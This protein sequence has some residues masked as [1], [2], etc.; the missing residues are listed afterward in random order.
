MVTDFGLA[1]VVDEATMTR[2]GSISGTPQYM[3]PEQARGESV[4][5]R[6]DLFSLGS[7][8]YTA[9]TGH[10]PFRAET[11]FGVIKRVCDNDPRSL[12]ESN[13]DIAEWMAAF[14]DKL[15]SKNRGDRFES[16]E[17]VAN[18]LH[19]E[20]GHM[21][22]PTLIPQPARDWCQKPVVVPAISLEAKPKES[23]EKPCATGNRSGWKFLAIGASLLALASVSALT[24]S[25]FYGDS[26]DH[27]EPRDMV[28][29]TIISTGDG[30]GNY[31]S[32]LALTQEENE[33]LEKFE[34]RISTT[35]DVQDGGV[36]F[37]RSNLGKLNV[38]THDKATVEM[39][40]NHTVAA[41]DKEIAAKI[42]KALK[43]N[44][45][46]DAKEIEGKLR[47]GKDAAIIAKFP[48]QKLTQKEIDAAEDLDELK[49]ALLIRNNSHHSNAEFNLFVPETFSLDLVTSAGP[50]KSTEIDGSVKLTTHGGN[51]EISNVSGT[52][53]IMSHGGNIQAG[54]IGS[55]T[56][57]ETHGGHIVILDVDGEFLATTHGGRISARHVNGAAEA[58]TH[59]GKI[60]FI[61]AS[62][63]VKAESRGGRITILKAHDAVVAEAHAGK[64]EVNFVDQPKGDSKL[65][66]HSG[67]VQVGYIEGIGFD[68][69]ASSSNGKISGAFLDGIRIE[70]SMQHEL[71]DGTAKLQ[72]TSENGSVKFTVIKED[73][74][75][76]H[77]DT[78]NEFETA[79]L[80]FQ[81]AYET[82]MAGKIDEAIELHKAAAQYE[83]TKVLATYNL[84]CAWALKG[85]KDRAFKALNQAV[86]FGMDDV[87]QFD[88]DSDLDS[89]RDDPRYEEVISRVKAM[90][91]KNQSSA[92]TAKEL[93]RL[94]SRGHSMFHS[95]KFDK[96]EKV[97]RTI[98]ELEPK[99]L[100]AAY[101][102]SSSIHA[103][104]KLD[105]ALEL[106]KI[107]ANSDSSEFASKA[108]Y[109]IACICSLK[110]D[111]DGAIEH[112]KK[113]INAGF[114]D[115]QHMKHDEELANIHDDKRFEELIALAKE[116]AKEKSDCTCEEEDENITSAGDT[117]F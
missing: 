79:Q 96:S 52:A 31:G 11:V 81:K 26:G 9:S 86:D 90:W 69:E 47:D 5:P 50:I 73:E 14:I 106:H 38:S 57:I 40:L 35:I 107:V 37:L 114:V 83:S 65:S 71:N 3:S 109:N 45:E 117:E 48:I 36:L 84:G 7:V 2:S 6:S 49:D 22:N 59:G 60:E 111:T 17:Q 103:L 77:Q 25:G 87:S 72:I 78:V 23:L 95:E 85:E 89:L 98:L 88:G 92:E 113:A 15:H 82:H 102:L 61:E 54:N 64:V 112:L 1:R 94:V 13:P 51:I 56:N 99:N 75:D 20:I 24:L 62:G 21:Q 18:L 115:I 74:L 55:D 58:M 108:I 32:L 101:M 80:A 66:S 91:K 104:G 67:S 29:T 33:R 110:K 19:G 53:N 16:A 27:I 4:D 93:T 105:E 43:M 28:T 116:L 46:I 97:F 100:E 70:G 76:E 10:S 12:R 63:P 41:A 44:Y 68:I 8:M 34:N 30:A 39:K 42:F